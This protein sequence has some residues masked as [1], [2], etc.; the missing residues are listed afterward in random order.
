MLRRTVIHGMRLRPYSWKTTAIFFGGAVTG[1]P[2]S[3]TTP[4]L[5]AS[6]PAMHLSSVVLPAPEGPT[7]QISSPLFAVK[8]MFC[9]ATKSP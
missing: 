9:S 4:P 8:E 5:G 2:S 3:S 6:R 7:M 1:S